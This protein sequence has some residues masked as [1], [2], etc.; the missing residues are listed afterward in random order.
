MFIFVELRLLF[1]K[2]V[3]EEEET[4]INHEKLW[5]KIHLSYIYY[6]CTYY[7]V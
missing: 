6:E 1:S 7:L 2:K 5:Y 4:A 3:S